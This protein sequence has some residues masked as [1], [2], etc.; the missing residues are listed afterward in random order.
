MRLW[1]MRGTKGEDSH[2]HLVKV[3]IPT[4]AHQKQ[5]SVVVW[6]WEGAWALRGPDTER[7]LAPCS[8]HVTARVLS[9]VNILKVKRP[10]PHFRT[11]PQTKTQLLGIESKLNSIG[12][13]QKSRYK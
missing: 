4:S 1:C 13:K 8:S 9:L 6:D 10:T 12:T 7:S 11:K 2:W 5:S 3:K